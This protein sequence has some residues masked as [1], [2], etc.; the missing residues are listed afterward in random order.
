MQ[1]LIENTIT[2]FFSTG[3]REFALDQLILDRTERV[4][5]SFQFLS[6]VNCGGDGSVV[7]RRLVIERLLTPG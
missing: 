6:P 1:L 2:F 7:E 5:R 3:T 4:C